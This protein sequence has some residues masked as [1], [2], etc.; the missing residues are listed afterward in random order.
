LEP[1]HSDI[2][3]PSDGLADEPH[4]APAAELDPRAEACRILVRLEASDARARELV[5]DAARPFAPG[6]EAAFLAELVYGTLRRRGRIDDLLG[7]VSHRPL[8]SLAPWVRNLLRLSLYQI[9]HVD[10]VPATVAVDA[11]CEIARRYGHDGVAKFINGCLRELCRQKTEDKLP[12]LPLHPVVRLAVES[13]HPLWMAERLS[14]VYGWERASEVLH[15][16][17]QVAPLT[18]RVNPLRARR[19]E[20]AGRLHQAG[21]HVEPCAWSPW[22]LRVKEHVEPRRLPGFQEGDFHVQDES[23]QL[24]GLLLNLQAGWQ[25][26]DVCA[27]PG[28]KTLQ[29]AELVGRQGRVWAF[30]RKPGAL[31]KLQGLL[32][33][34]GYHQVGGETRDGLYPREDLLGRLD[35]VLVDAPCS[36]LGLL[37]RRPEARWQQR[38]DASMQHS[39]RQWRLLKASVQYLKPGGV[40][41][42]STCTWEPREN[43][44][45]VARFLDEEPGLAFERAERFLPSDLCT[46]EGFLRIWPGF[47]G[48]DGLFAARFRRI[49]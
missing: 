4:P 22:G 44:E 46:R 12:P 37:R 36:A 6:P 29:L 19:D 33:R 49:S 2:Q 48:M 47:D 41:V 14:D 26:A 23:G 45:V 30:D 17:N 15:A 42:Y 38:P 8:E 31:E 39:E 40:L 25:V 28:G 5:D 20:L 24:L 32:R 43:E 27:A 34:Q 11:A 16:S 10:R 1:K 7:R 35:A 21:F 18:L 3:P 9:L 13:S